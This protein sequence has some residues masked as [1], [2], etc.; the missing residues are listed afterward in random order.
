MNNLDKQILTVLGSIV[1]GLILVFSGFTDLIHDFS[2]S[3]LK[4]LYSKYAKDNTEAISES[5]G[6]SVEIFIA[7][8]M[9]LTTVSYTHLTLPTI[10]LV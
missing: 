2:I 6:Y 3:A 8:I 9:M 7:I 10:L 5:V 4:P 1:L